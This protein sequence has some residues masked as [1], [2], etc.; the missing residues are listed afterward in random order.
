MQFRFEP[1]SA[2]RRLCVT[3]HAEPG[4]ACG[5]DEAKNNGF[6]RTPIYIAPIRFIAS[7]TF[8]PLSHTTVSYTQLTLPPIL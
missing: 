1:A 3:P 7:S 2:G 5:V 8:R 4:E 6:R